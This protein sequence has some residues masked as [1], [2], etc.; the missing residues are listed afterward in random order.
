MKGNSV[1]ALRPWASIIIPTLVE[2]PPTVSSLDP[3]WMTQRKTTTF[4]LE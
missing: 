2:D 4:P 3:M 1:T